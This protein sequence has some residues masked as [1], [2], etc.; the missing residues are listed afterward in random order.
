MLWA[1]KVFYESISHKVMISKRLRKRKMVPGTC[2]FYYPIIHPLW[3]ID[4]WIT[5]EH[6]ISINP[7]D[8]RRQGR[9]TN[10]K[11]TRSRIEK[12]NKVETNLIKHRL[13]QLFSLYGERGH[14]KIFFPKKSTTS[15][16]QLA[17]SFKLYQSS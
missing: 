4:N 13:P 14:T 11:R 1:M 3:S 6:C 2:V 16:A 17:Q 15:K 5:I 9:K 7:P 12:T 8:L 10:L